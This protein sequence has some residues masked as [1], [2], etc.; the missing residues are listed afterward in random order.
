MKKSKRILS[1]LLILSLFVSIFSG[2]LPLPA[3]AAGPADMDLD[4]VKDENNEYIISDNSVVLYWNSIAGASNYVISRDDLGP[5]KDITVTAATYTITGL[6]PN[7]IYHFA[8][9]AKDSMGADISVTDNQLNVLTGNMNFSCS[10]ISPSSASNSEGGLNPG[11]KLQWEIPQ[12]WDGSDFVTI[13]SNKIDYI[14]GAGTD[15]AAMNV[16]N[17]E[18]FYD[19]GGSPDNYDVVKQGEPSVSKLVYD[20]DITNGVLSYD[21]WKYKNF[22]SKVINDDSLKAGTV[23]YMKLYPQFNTTLKNANNVSIG[24]TISKASVLNHGYASSPLHV[25]IGKDSNNNITCTIDRINYDTN[26]GT[27]VINFKYEVYSSSDSGMMTPS[28]EGYEFEQYGDLS[29]PI[30]IFLPRKNNTSTYYYKV[31]AKSDNLDSIQSAIIQYNMAG[32]EAKPPIPQNLTVTGTGLITNGTDTGAAA[33]LKWEKPK[34]LDNDE[35]RY[36]ILVSLNKKDSTDGDGT[37]YQEVINGKPYDIRYRTVKI[38]NESDL[39]FSEDGYVK[40]NLNGLQLL[41]DYDGFGDNYPARLRLNKIYYVKIY[42]EKITSGLKSDYSLPASFTTPGETRKPPVPSYFGMESVSTNE[43]GLV[44]QKADINITNYNFAP[45]TDYTVTYD[46][47][48]SDSLNRDANGN[49]NSFIY[50]GNYPDTPAAGLN[51][52]ARRA[53]INSFAGKPNVVARFGPAVKPDTTYYFTIRLKL[54]VDGAADSSYSDFSYVVPVTTKR[55][56]I[57]EPGDEAIKPKASADFGIDVDALG[58]QKLKSNEVTLKWTKQQDGVTYRLIRTSKAI[59]QNA[60]VAEIQADAQYNFLDCGLSN[61]MTPDSVGKFVYTMQRLQPNTI[62]YFSL[63][64]ERLLQDGS[65]NVSEWITLPVTTNILESPEIFSFVSDKTFNAYTALKVQWRSKETYDGQIW[66]KSETDTDYTLWTNTVIT[67]D[68]PNDLAGTDLRMNYAIINQLKSNTRYYIKA[69]NTFTAAGST[70]TVFSKFVGPIVSRT[71]FRQSDYEDNQK[72]KNDETIFNEEMKDIRYGLYW[73]IDNTNEDT[74]IKLRE[75]RVINHMTNDNSKTLTIDMGYFKR[76][77][78]EE[79]EDKKASENNEIIVPYGVFNYIN[80]YKETL[81]IRTGFGE[82]YLKPGMIDDNNLKIAEMKNDI[83]SES[84]SIK[85]IYVRLIFEN[86]GKTGSD[87][88]S[89][90]DLLAS[91]VLKFEMEVLGMDMTETKMDQAIDSELTDILNDKLSDFQDES[92]K[93]KDTSKELT[94]L[95]NEYRA[96]ILEDLGEYVDE[97]IDD[98][99]EEG[100]E[101]VTFLSGPI[102][103]KYIYTPLAGI[104]YYNAYIYRDKEWVKLT[105]SIDYDENTVDFEIK[106]TGSFAILKNTSSIKASNGQVSE[107]LTKL[108]MKYDIASILTS[109]GSLNGQEIVNVKQL[110][111]VIQ[112]IFGEEAS[113]ELMVSKM[114]E[115]LNLNSSF[116]MLGDSHKLTREEAAYLAMRMYAVKTGVSEN[117]YKP[118]K[119]IDLSDYKSI[120]P[121]YYKA[122]IMAVDLKVITPDSSKRIQPKG[123]ISIEDALSMIVRTLTLLGE[124]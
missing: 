49:Y 101:D 96:E 50:L 42:S 40:Y 78:D 94:K 108:D 66:V 97:E 46:V 85:D 114:T 8:V 86:M 33:R 56:D 84:P 122:V 87:V 83:L 26:D 27:E 21:W 6:S 34:G 103:F 72:D 37:Y 7:R 74:K 63:R 64:T 59:A 29:K 73:I 70:Q 88:S 99:V 58:N 105:S 60:T 71:E 5:S 76:A 25:K 123:Q 39:D 57:E 43:I 48:I 107:Q 28:L 98:A 67:H 12:I 1:F 54:D 81:I 79:D 35:L 22:A 112:K 89:K 104:L 121:A 111:G 119:T 2:I 16:G 80:N 65:Y 82:V 44:W 77:P 45:N 17:Y 13:D 69:R 116:R 68:K 100:P 102:G 120:N 113:D 75:A 124:I 14:V 93:D 53:T 41:Q 18:V 31:Y 51:Y 30:E 19:G 24:K 106:R 117:T 109:N 38:V 92:E 91:D 32:E 36:Y 110:L 47:Y 4:G 15:K 20:A 52:N 118:T 23:Y 11:F 90:K 3:N 10:D 115:K 9:K 55:G 95:I 62:Y 61:P